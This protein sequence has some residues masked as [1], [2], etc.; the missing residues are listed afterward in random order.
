M[1]GARRPLITGLMA[2]VLLV[3]GFGLWATLAR[4]ESAIIAPGRVELQGGPHPL[5][6]PEGG[7]VTRVFVSEG[8]LVHEGQALLQL[9]DSL[10]A[11]ELAAIEAQ[12]RDLALRRTRLIA[13]RDGS[14]M[15]STPSDTA[16]QALFLARRAAEAQQI[17]ILDER[18]HQIL[19]QIEG[20]QAEAEAIAQ[21]Q[22]L[23]G[24][25]LAVLQ[26]LLDQGLTQ[27]S[28]VLALER[29]RAAL[30]GRQ[31]QAG[32]AI[33]RAEA[34]L[35]EVT[36]QIDTIA[37]IRRAEATEALRELDAAETVLTAR[38][39]SLEAQI[40]ALTLRAP[41][42]GRVWAL[43]IT[44]TPSVLRAGEP[45]LQLLPVDSP[46]VISAMVAPHDIDQITNGQ[47]ARLRISSFDPRMN[48]EL[49]GHVADIAPDTSTDPASNAPFYRVELA[50][51]ADTTALLPGMEAEVFFATG[52][53]SPAHYLLHP[54]TAYFRRALREG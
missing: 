3:A 13:E 31:A 26:G 30:T 16:E 44:R 51:A 49:I 7:V 22:A 42:A 23:V 39:A 43:Q 6:H 10:L 53:Q 47:Q 19:R 35:D 45:A 28:R 4:I 46:L 2:L 33:A 32:T 52:A 17:A 12:L 50:L 8:E 20:L 54:L 25:E 29:T 36:A 38:Q 27:A 24:E 21:E 18:H 40:A 34:A 1:T 15:E 9:D 48:T 14:D 41:I 37:T 5:R 11:P